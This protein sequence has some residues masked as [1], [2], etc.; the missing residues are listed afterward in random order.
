MFQKPIQK[1][2]LNRTR[3][4]ISQQFRE[5]KEQEIKNSQNKISEP[6]T[7]KPDAPAQNIKNQ[8]KPTIKF[9][10]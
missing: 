9:R 7:P 8:P 10:R 2:F 5:N 3:E 6:Q 1:C 4:Y